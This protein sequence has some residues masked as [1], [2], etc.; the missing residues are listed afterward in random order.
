MFPMSYILKEHVEIIKI[1]M[2][3]FNVTIFNG[4]KIMGFLLIKDKYIKIR[5]LS[6][7]L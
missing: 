4:I 1:Y 2:V 6:I 5:S 3:K 7:K